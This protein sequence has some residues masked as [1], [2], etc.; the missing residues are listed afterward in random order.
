MAGR[1]HLESTQKTHKKCI[2]AVCVAAL[3]YCSDIVIVIYHI[4]VIL[5]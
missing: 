5:L 3:V 4:F 2:E 1:N